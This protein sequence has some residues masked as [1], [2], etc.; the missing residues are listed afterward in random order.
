MNVRFTIF[1]IIESTFFLKG[2]KSRLEDVFFWCEVQEIKSDFLRPNTV[3]SLRICTLSGTTHEQWI[4]GRAE[5][6]A[7]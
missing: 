7:K 2:F 4:R 1:P 5:P 6:W 3:Q